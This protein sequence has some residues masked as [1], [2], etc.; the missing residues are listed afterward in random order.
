MTSKTI[1]PL[2]LCLM[3]FSIVM[4][5]CGQPPMSEPASEPTETV[6]ATSSF[7]PPTPAL[8]SPPTSIPSPTATAAPPATPTPADEPALD[9]TRESGIRGQVLRGPMCG[10]PV[11]VD[12]S[13]PDQPFSATFFVLDRQGNWI[14]QF[15]T[16]EQGYFQVNLLPGVYTIVPDKSA[17]LISPGDQKKEVAVQ[18]GELVQVTLAFDTGIR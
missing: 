4:P 10:G 12:D 9:E 7:D 13:C 5:G 16:D 18:E 15:Q 2:I 8:T 11:S 3:L 17:P 6:E 1:L 14:T